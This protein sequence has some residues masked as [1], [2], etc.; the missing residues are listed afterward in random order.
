MRMLPPLLQLGLAAGLAAAADVLDQP[1]RL[2]PIIPVGVVGMRNRVRTE[3]KTAPTWTALTQSRPATLF[4]HFHKAGGTTMC[5][6]F[7]HSGWANPRSGGHHLNCGCGH[8]LLTHVQRGDAGA[9]MAHGGWRN[10]SGICMIEAASDWTSTGPGGAFVKFAAGWHDRGG[11]LATAMVEPWHRMHSSYEREVSL[12]VL[13][14]EAGSTQEGF[15]FSQ[16]ASGSSSYLHTKR[17]GCFNEDDFY[18]RFLTGNSCGAA[19]L[20]DDHLDQAKRVLLQFDAVSLR[21]HTNSKAGVEV[22]DLLP[23]SSLHLPPPPPPPR[24]A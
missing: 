20:T 5:K 10:G 23:S 4:L 13:R 1:D 6:A 19:A 21:T 24:P 9:A 17:W 12:S 14:G 7:R 22:V 15:N 18:V 2:A 8:P 3:T 11:L 16:F